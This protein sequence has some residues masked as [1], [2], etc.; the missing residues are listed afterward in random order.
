M[1]REL[2]NG[3]GGHGEVRGERKGRGE[4]VIERREWRV[5]ERK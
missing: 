4:E 3:G 5:G 2:G 1:G